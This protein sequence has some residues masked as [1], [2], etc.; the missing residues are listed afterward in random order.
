MLKSLITK[1]GLVEDGAFIVLTI[2]SQA[3]IEKVGYK[4]C[5]KAQAWR[6]DNKLNN[7]KPWNIEQQNNTI[8]LIR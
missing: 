1:W 3:R 7:D 4:D 2:V 6:H 5:A 8:R